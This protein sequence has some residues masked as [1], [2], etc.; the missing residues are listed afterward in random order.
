M[1]GAHYGHDLYGALRAGYTRRSREAGFK[2]L[3]EVR[4][5]M[6]PM[7]AGIEERIT[8]SM[9]LHTLIECAEHD[10]IPTDQI[11]DKIKHSA[12]RWDADFGGHRALEGIALRQFDENMAGGQEDPVVTGNLGW[13]NYDA[14]VDAMA[15]SVARETLKE[16]ARLRKQAQEEAAELRERMS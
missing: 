14:E 13:E 10:G 9:A 5:R 1:R 3:A 6:D 12:E 7:Q 4:G 16:E 11:R 2:L 15:S 8:F